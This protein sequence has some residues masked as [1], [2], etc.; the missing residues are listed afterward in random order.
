MEL[1]KF[2]THQ[3]QLPKSILKIIPLAL[4]L[5]MQIGCG[6][7]AGTNSPIGSM[8]TTTSV[9][10]V[11][12]SAEIATDSVISVSFNTEIDES[13]ISSSTFAIT[14]PSGPVSGAIIYKNKIAVFT[15]TVPFLPKTRYIATLGTGIKAL[16]G[17]S[18]EPY[19]WEVTTGK[20]LLTRSTVETVPSTLFGQ[21]IHRAATVTAWPAI[22]FGTLRVWDS[23]AIWPD[24]EPRKGEWHFDNLDKYVA[25]AEQNGVQL[26]LPLS[27]T[28]TWAS[29][30]P[31]EK[32]AYKFGNAAEPANIEDWK[33][34]IR[35]I[36]TRYK[37]RIHYY[38]LWNEINAKN[39]YTGTAEQ[40]VVLAKTAYEIIKEVDPTATV[41][42]PSFSP[43][44]SNTKMF[45][46]YIAKGGMNYADII[47]YHF[48]VSPGIPENA[49]SF[50]NKIKNI[51]ESAQIINRS[52]I[53]NLAGIL[54]V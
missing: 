41:L 35:T 23:G 1:I 50:I 51:L 6:G 18:I 54:K 25:L 38:E 2:K 14:G 48:Y 22:Q 17:N 24:L 26:I 28:P 37:G 12:K 31:A 4:L 10:Q 32:S 21:H 49:I 47:A 36:A 16:N 15:P 46:D 45:S 44:E 40:M 11:S 30:R 5:L 34:F 33:G 53:L 20:D 29:A 43:P 8:S 13:S 52:G 27:Q 39:F 7:G 3:S 9:S 19:T 42:S